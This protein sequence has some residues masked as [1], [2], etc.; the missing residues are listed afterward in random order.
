[1]DMNFLTHHM[2]VEFETFMGFGDDDLMSAITKFLRLSG[3][4]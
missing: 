4:F 2:D 1:M 3:C